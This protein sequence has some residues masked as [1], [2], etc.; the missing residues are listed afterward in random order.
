MIITCLIIL[1]DLDCIIDP[2]SMRHSLE[3]SDLLIPLIKVGVSDR[4][5]NRPSR[6]IIFS[7]IFSSSPEFSNTILVD[8]SF[9]IVNLCR[10]LSSL[11]F[12]KNVFMFNI[13]LTSDKFAPSFFFFFCFFVIF[14]C[15][16]F[17]TF[18]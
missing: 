16:N 4:G 14:C 8:N 3:F 12:S 17:K 9:V 2:V 1:C 10:T 6:V 15:S 5:I 18:S 11:S 13:L 7:S